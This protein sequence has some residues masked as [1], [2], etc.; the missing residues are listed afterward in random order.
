MASECNRHRIQAARTDAKSGSIEM[1]HFQIQVFCSASCHMNEPIHYDI[2]GDIHGRFEKL[3]GLMDRMGYQRDGDGFIPPA[4]H[5]ALFLGDLIDPKLGYALPGG[6]R[7]TLQAVKWMTDAGHAHCLMGNH[8]LNALYF[9]SK[10]PDG[11]WLRH[12]SDINKRM[13]QGTLTDFPDYEDPAGEWLAVWMPWM[14][15][16]P[17]TLDLGGFRM[18]HAAWHQESVDHLRGRNFDDECFFIAASD[19]SHPDGK[20]MEILLKG[21]EIELPDDVIYTDPQ[22]NRRDHIRVRWW[23]LPQNGMCY[24]ELVFP[25]N[26]MIP[27]DPVSEESF[28]QI[29]SYPVNSPPVFFGHYLK[30]AISPLRPERRN[31]ACLDHS[32]ATEGPL[33][34]YRW[35]GEN[36]IHSAQYISHE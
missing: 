13:H 4:G 35:R 16:L 10:G 6:V 15:S 11:R 34:A 28:A 8:E 5:K 1:L 25:A 20:A 23:E 36:F 32:A 33:V 18:V 7:S 14:K 26:P 3:A 2:I 17:F 9:H 22:G 27:D 24:N 31:V 12:H 30:P 19:K 29:P 21:I